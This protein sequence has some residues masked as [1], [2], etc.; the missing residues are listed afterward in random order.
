MCGA[1]DPS[2]ANLPS[3]R[4][5]KQSKTQ[6]EQSNRDT[7]EVTRILSQLVL[8][9][10]YKTKSF[11]KPEYNALTQAYEKEPFSPNSLS[12]FQG[13]RSSFKRLK[14]QL[15]IW[16]SQFKSWSQLGGYVT[17]QNHPQLPCI[18]THH[19]DSGLHM[20]PTCTN[21]HPSANCRSNDGLTW[22]LAVWA[23]YH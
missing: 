15:Q 21:H 11:P 20:P 7:H 5:E 6:K 23:S 17:G 4:L 3:Q 8:F 9:H 2:L 22:S 18:T 19:P 16:I 14:L 13:C 10:Y 12:L 1:K